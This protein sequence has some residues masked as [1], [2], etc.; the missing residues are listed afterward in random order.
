[1]Y[2]FCNFYYPSTHQKYCCQIFGYDFEQL[3]KFLYIKC[4]IFVGVV[5]IKNMIA[6]FFGIDFE[7]VVSFLCITVIIFISIVLIKNNVTNFWN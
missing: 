6:S 7:L 3:V 2:S 5:P 4:M 1:M